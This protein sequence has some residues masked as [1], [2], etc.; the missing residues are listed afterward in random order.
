MTQ[1]KGSKRPRTPPKTSRERKADF[2]RLI[3]N[4][5][6]VDPDKP[7]RWASIFFLTKE[8]ADHVKR[9]RDEA[10]FEGSKASRNAA[11]FEEMLRVYLAWRR[12]DGRLPPVGDV[13][14][15]DG[16]EVP[17]AALSAQLVAFRQSVSELRATM[18]EVEAFQKQ[19]LAAHH[20]ERWTSFDRLIRRLRGADI[21]G[22]DSIEERRVW[23]R[24]VDEYLQSLLASVG[25]S[26]VDQVRV[27]EG[28]GQLFSRILRRFEF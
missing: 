15:L 21:A 17:S 3:R 1:A 9:I 4:R 23:H 22:A 12:G 19:I 24:E 7:E 6:G 5:G 11:L 28:R 18:R 10:R 2:D 27:P 13:E 16:G 14:P 20:A 25:N 26:A 8:S